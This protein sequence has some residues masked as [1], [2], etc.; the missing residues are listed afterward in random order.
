M[1][2][3][4]SCPVRR[5]HIVLALLTFAGCPSKDPTPPQDALPPGDAPAADQGPAEPPVDAPAADALPSFNL[6]W[7]IYSERD[8]GSEPGTRIIVD[9]RGELQLTEGAGPPRDA[10]LTGAD[11]R[12]LT[13]LLSR[14]EVIDE[15]LSPRACGTPSPDR[16][17]RIRLGIG[18]NEVVK[19]ITGCQ[20]PAYADLRTLLFAFRDRYFDWTPGTC[21][22]PNVQRYMA[23][24][25]GA[26][27]RPVCGSRIQ[28]ACASPRCSCDGRNIIG[29]DYS[30][31]PFAY[32]GRCQTDAGTGN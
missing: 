4:G 23:P 16:P 31:E 18:G 30:V 27:A 32:F 21:P 29:C 13:D 5:I 20:Q 26:E 12:E 1:R 28:D 14:P 17:E 15:I 24:G 10:R 22:P 8:G 9:S 6:M 2:V 19:E 11:Q 7:W 3:A 25:C